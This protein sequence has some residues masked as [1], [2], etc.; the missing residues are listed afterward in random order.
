MHRVCHRL[1]R[2]HLLRVL[3]LLEKAFPI[4]LVLGDGSLAARTRSFVS[5]S[6]KPEVCIMNHLNHVIHLR[7]V[8]FATHPR[9]QTE[10]FWR[11]TGKV[12]LCPIKRRSCANCR[13][14]DTPCVPSRFV[15][16]VVGSLRPGRES[17]TK[18]F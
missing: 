14:A 6:L 11:R 17:I 18:G 3:Q 7:F 1:H 10:M 5:C 4:L 2:C 9:Q 12:L 16:A 15:P 13:S 8:V